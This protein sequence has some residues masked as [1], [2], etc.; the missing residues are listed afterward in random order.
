[1]TKASP[2]A[3][4]ACHFRPLRVVIPDPPALPTSAWCRPRRSERSEAPPPADHPD[5]DV[6]IVVVGIGFSVVPVVVVVRELVDDGRSS[7]SSRRQLQRYRLMMVVLPT[8]TAPRTTTR[9]FTSWD[10][11][12]AAV[13]G[14]LLAVPV[15]RMYPSVDVIGL[16]A[17]CPAQHL[18]FAD[19]FLKLEERLHTADVWQETCGERL[20]HD[21]VNKLGSR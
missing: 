5:T 15:V 10:N 9:Y 19:R 20:Q 11:A 14:P 4:A 7:T 3:T 12:S 21:G 8:P 2:E 13:F 17:G 1:M 18:V 16:G 6:A